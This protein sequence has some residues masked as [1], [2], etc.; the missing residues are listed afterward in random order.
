MNFFLMSV[1]ILVGI[2]CFS[3]KFKAEYR[4]EKIPTQLD[5]DK[6]A[7]MMSN[8]FD[9]AEKFKLALYVEKS[10]S[11]FY[12]QKQMQNAQSTIERLSLVFFNMDGKIYT[13]INE[14][15]QLHEK[16][17]FGT[18]FVVENKYGNERWKLTSESKV[19]GDYKCFKA[20]FYE[21]SSKDNKVVVWFAPSINYS[22]G[23]GYYVGFPGLVLEVEVIS[24]LPY[25]IILD[26][27]KFNYSE[28]VDF[29]KP[30]KGKYI[31]IEEYNAIGI[32]MRKRQKEML[33]N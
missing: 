28:K 23:P 29:S 20:V 24:K 18:D 7:N 26:N 27:V 17:S 10:N 13:Y 30:E 15:I 8:L 12:V 25:R 21:E 3:Q 5:S 11:V 31:T 6:I 1:F 16:N 19:I 4:I 22:F 2:E 33:K 14:K 32:D 9:S